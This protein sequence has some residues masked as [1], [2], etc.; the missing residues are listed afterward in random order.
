M[1]IRKNNGIKYVAISL[2]LVIVFGAVGVS[3]NVSFKQL[4]ADA[5]AKVIAP[6]I[7]EDLEEG[8]INLGAFPGPDIYSDVNVH[9]TFTHGG[10]IWATTTR[11]TTI[12][13]TQKDL[14]RN[15]VIEILNM[16]DTDDLTFTMPATS[17]MLALLPE[18]G[19]TRTWLFHNATTTGDDTIDITLAAGAGMELVG[20]A[21]TADVIAAETWLEV[22]CTRKTYIS[23]INENIVCLLEEMIVAD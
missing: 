15:K 22:T 23:S 7:A 2:A 16:T 8:D 13:L 14:D 3:A 19:S 1:K 6:Q 5:V 9:G 20:V 17:T 4:L 11:D 12:T 18:P 21:N 10:N